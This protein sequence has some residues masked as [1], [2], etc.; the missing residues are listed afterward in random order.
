MKNYYI[1]IFFIILGTSL[2][3]SAENLDKTEQYWIK[4][5]IQIKEGNLLTAAELIENAI[6]EEQY[7][8]SE[9]RADILV[10][11]SN[12]A[13]SLYF[14][15]G[16][17]DKAL[18]NFKISLEINKRLEKEKGIA[19]DLNSI[20]AV[21][22]AKGQY[23]NAIENYKTA[24]EI[25]IRLGEETEAAKNFTFIGNTYSNQALYDKAVENYEKALKIG[26]T[27][28]REDII[29]VNLG[30]IGGVYFRWG[31]YEKAIK[32][33]TASLK[34]IE[35]LLKLTKHLKKHLVFL[36]PSAI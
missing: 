18:A 17:Y 31:K 36:L 34:L 12:K 1:I 3:C 13:G 28:N 11:L 27:Y 23:E 21:Y 35:N 33:Y 9:P 20:G 25:N 30:N 14:Q 29:S 26:E 6:V 2:F 8:R 4:A 24:L 15:T 22:N 7:N 32:N 10:G 5:Q 19:S 16:L